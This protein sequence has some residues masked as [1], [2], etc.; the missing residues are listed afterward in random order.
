MSDDHNLT[1]DQRAMPAFVRHMAYQQVPLT[2]DTVRG[3][4]DELGREVT[5]EYNLPPEE[6]AVLD[7]AISKAFL[8]IRD[9]VTQPLRTS[10]M[11]AISNWAAMANLLPRTEGKNEL[12]YTEQPFEGDLHTTLGAEFGKPRTSIKHRLFGVLYSIQPKTDVEKPLLDRCRD[13]LRS[14]GLIPLA[15]AKKIRFTHDETLL[16]NQGPLQ[17]GALEEEDFEAGNE[18]EVESVTPCKAPD[19][20]MATVVFKHKKSAQVPIESFEVVN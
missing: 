15:E 8:A 17:F 14:Q 7:A 11:R 18:Y 20:D 10:Q 4:L 5:E 19:T 1:P 6:H 3:I 12:G 9:R 13:A 2:C 16:V